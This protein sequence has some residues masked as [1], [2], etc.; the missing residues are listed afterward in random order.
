MPEN[1]ELK[2]Y[3]VLGMK[4]GVHKSKHRSTS[5]RAAIA[6]RSNKKV[7]KN[8]EK[9]KENDKKKKN[10]LELGKKAAAAKLAYEKDPTNKNLR[11]EYKQANKEYKKSLGQ[12]TSYR[13]GAIRQEIGRD[14]SRKYL[15][16]AKKVKKLLNADPSNK[17]LQKEYNN[18]MSKQD[19]ERAKARRASDVGQKRMLKKATIKRT[20]TNTIKAAGVSAAIGIGTVAVNQYLKKQGGA[21]ISTDQIR[22]YAEAGKKALNFT[23]YFY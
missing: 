17:S 16:E 11:S 7:D 13:K 5:L 21:G 10:A 15:S 3:G 4:W 1:N 6:R 14:L 2:H 12:N 18:W 19:V 8:F 9:W 23:K 22:R 20:M